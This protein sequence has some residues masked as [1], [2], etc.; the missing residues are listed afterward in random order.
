LDPKPAEDH[1]QTVAGLA[2]HYV[3]GITC[4]A[5]RRS[6]ESAA[7]TQKNSFIR[8]RNID[9]CDVDM[10]SGLHQ[11]LE[12]SMMPHS[13]V[14]VRQT[15]AI[16]P[17]VLYFGTPVIL[18]TTTNLD[19]TTNITPMS[20][21]WALADR[22][23]LGLGSASQGAANLRERRECVIN[24]AC[25]ELWGQ[26]EL[27]ARVTGRIEVP[28]HKVRLGYK[29]AADKFGLAGFTSFPSETVLP[30]RIAECPLQ[31]EAILLTEHGDWGTTPEAPI[32]FETKVNRV[33]AHPEIVIHG[34]DRIDTAHWHPLFYVFRHYFAVGPDLGANFKDQL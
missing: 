19:G 12:S 31:I 8:C 17:P 23:V 29:Y 1:G 28:P 16:R 7:R 26:I 27:L 9:A 33:H 22:V 14:P 2:E 11:A 3:H 5:F 15:L 32:I 20:S 30:S 18:L 21:A 24:V 34:S 6:R 4:N 25:A 10:L 13:S